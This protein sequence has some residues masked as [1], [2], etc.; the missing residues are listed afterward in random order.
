MIEYKNLTPDLIP[1]FAAMRIRQLREE[2]ATGDEDL[3]PALLD[4]YGRHL[5]DS[6]FVAYLAWD[7]ERIVGTVAV[8]L[9][10]KPAWF[11]CPTGRIGLLSSMWT[12]VAYRRQG[13]ARRLLTLVL[14]EAKARGCGTVWVTASQM[15]VPF[16]AR[17]GF[18]P[19][20]RFMQ[21]QL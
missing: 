5:G 15:G 8:S 3:L 12:E 20:G 7:G 1:T 16:Y 6:T 21:Y 18:A 17:C 2:G 9:V 11:G 13:I 19:N 4:Y 10:E 14:D